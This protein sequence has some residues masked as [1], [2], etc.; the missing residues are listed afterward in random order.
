M[1]ERRKQV[2]EKEDPPKLWVIVENC[3]PNT[4]DKSRKKK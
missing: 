3:F 4:T 1:L 2:K